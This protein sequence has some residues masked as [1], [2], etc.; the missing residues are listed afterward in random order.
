MS[1][2]HLRIQAR[3]GIEDMITKDFCIRHSK[4]R[5][6]MSGRNMPCFVQSGN[7]RE[8]LTNIQ[9]TCYKLEGSKSSYCELPL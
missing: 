7:F 3:K 2:S 1:I 5:E 4:L 8:S 6:G 9:C